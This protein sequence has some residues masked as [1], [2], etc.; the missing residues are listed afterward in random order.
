MHLS[1]CLMTSLSDLKG[2][3]KTQVRKRYKRSRLAVSF[4]LKVDAITSSKL[5]L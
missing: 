3:I 4:I 5:I 2:F 1:L